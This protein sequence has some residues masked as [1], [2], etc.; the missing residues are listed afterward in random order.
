MRPGA[1]PPDPLIFVHG[2]NFKTEMNGSLKN[3][4]EK[5]CEKFMENFIKAIHFQLSFNKMLRNSL[6]N[7]DSSRAAERV[8]AKTVRK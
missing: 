7:F 1:P 6:I 4:L 2:F 3:K 8:A 5:L